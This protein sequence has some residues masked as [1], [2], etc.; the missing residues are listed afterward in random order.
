ML[1][2]TRQIGEAVLIGH[3]ITIRVLEV[4]GVHVRLGIEAP[5]QIAVHR[6]EIYEQIQRDKSNEE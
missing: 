6:Q 3:D 5:Q 1:V 2:L 4:K